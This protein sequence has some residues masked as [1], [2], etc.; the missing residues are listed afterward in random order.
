MVRGQDGQM[1]NLRDKNCK[2]AIHLPTEKVKCLIPF[3]VWQE[4]EVDVF[5]STFETVK[6]IKTKIEE[7]I[8]DNNAKKQ[9]ESDDYGIYV[10]EWCYY[11][12]VLKKLCLKVR[13]V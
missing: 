5:D 12:Q 7:E 2:P 3:Y 4:Q 1:C 9:C 11:Y 13:I 6:V 10:D 8:F